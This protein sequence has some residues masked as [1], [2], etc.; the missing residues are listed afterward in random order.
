MFHLVS[1]CN[2]IFSTVHIMTMT[3]NY[4]CHY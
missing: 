1:L 2:A 4:K 3:A